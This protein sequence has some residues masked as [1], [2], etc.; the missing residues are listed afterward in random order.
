M[1]AHRGASSLAT[2]N[3]IEAFQKSVDLGAPGIEL[4]I[5]WLSSG[6]IAVYHDS[7]VS[8]FFEVP[9]HVPG[10][11]LSL[12][13]L[14][15]LRSLK[16]LPGTAHQ[17]IPLLEE[18]FQTT[19]QAS[20]FDIEIKC[21][22]QPADPGKLT[23][24]LHCIN[25]AGLAHRVIISSFDPRVLLG[26]KQLDSGIPAG[27]I[28]DDGSKDQISRE[29]PWDQVLSI[30]DFEK[31]RY[32]MNSDIALAFSKDRPVLPWTVDEVETGMAL[33][34]KGVTGVITNTPQHYRTLLTRSS[35]I[36]FPS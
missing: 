31:P 26:W 36:S 16:P 14:E 1:Y 21:Y 11:R 17:G 12:M 35:A 8:R 30:P 13:D 6:Q 33:L 3:T 20:A 34:Q 7:E 19:G 4:D 10:G 29:A 32:S 2:E 15:T 24:L 25:N 28:Y 27:L 23:S 9:S 22:D 18:V 5:Q